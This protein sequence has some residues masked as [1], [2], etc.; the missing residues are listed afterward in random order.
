MNTIDAPAG[1]D[2]LS[3]LLA[4]RSVALV[5]ASGR[6]GNLGGAAARLLSRFEFTGDVWVVHP[7]E[8]PV[9]GYRCYADLAALPGTPDVAI[10]AIPAA[11]IVDA[12]RQCA[13]HGIRN[14][15]A[16]AGGFAEA[17]E[18]GRAQQAALAE[19]C[20]HHGIRLC[21]P[22]CLGIINTHTRFTGTFTTALLDMDRL[23][24]GSIAMV[25]QSGGLSTVSLALA[26]RAGFGFRYVISCGN[27]AV[28]SI[29]DFTRA[30]IRDPDTR[31][32]A[33]YVEAI[34]DGAEFL[35]SLHEARQAGKPVII[36]KGGASEASGRAALAH[37]GRL[38]GADRAF[39]AVIRAAGAIRVDSIEEMLDVALL[40]STLGTTLPRGPNVAITTFGGGAGVLAVDQAERH[41]LRAPL[42]GA[43]T[44]AWLESRLPPIAAV[45]NPVDLTP[46]SVN[47]PRYLT[48]LPQALGV[49]TRDENYDAVLFL[50]SAMRNRER[51]VIG[52]VEQL[53]ANSTVPVTVSWPLASPA[54]L[55]GLRSIGVYAFPENARA[56]RAIGKLTA[57]GQHATDAM[58]GSPEADTPVR[59][60]KWASAD[61]RSRVISEHDVAAMLREAQLPVAAGELVRAPEDLAHVSAQV[62]FPWAIK[63]ISA[64]ITHRADAGLLALNID[65]VE[66]AQDVYA[67]YRATA[68]R[69]GIELE[70]CYVQQM[71]KGGS[72]LL[73]SAFSDA[74][75]GVMITCAAGGGLTELIDDAVV[76]AAPLSVDAAACAIGKLRLMRKRSTTLSD[77]ALAH[78]ARYLADF[79]LAASTIPWRE[80]TLELNPVLCSDDGA[81][82]VDGL[83][84]IG[85]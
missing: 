53:R 21:G 42:P 3:R 43:D 22:N 67:R 16:W 64:A 19:L 35:R 1:A 40:A 68:D 4:P 72:E 49:L 47:D 10:L 59:W 24:T 56:A 6:D 14:V 77:A 2:D 84:I 82:A 81:V 15:I 33:M 70:G 32:I 79:S 60:E 63:G 57:A 39:D 48:Q 52:V 46:Q 51:E 78:A 38:A 54:A 29:A 73:F 41:G 18:E 80:F 61:A 58:T 62:P 83:L 76:V 66:A 36:L 85:D 13:E 8:Q 26:Q 37:T 11:G 20:R 30:L 7:S 71:I 44:R 34:T 45:G 5:G 17:G 50:S 65:S 25:S 27:E 75:F 55:E 74:T 69:L 31:V 9:A 23:N 28:L 12:I